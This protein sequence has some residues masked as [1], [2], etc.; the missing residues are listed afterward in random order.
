M[1]C[2]SKVL[3]MYSLMHW[4]STHLLNASRNLILD[5]QESERKKIHKGILISVSNKLDWDTAQ[6]RDKSWWEN[7]RSAFAI[8]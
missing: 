5:H 7:L 4:I 3:K 1:R 8:S 2:P 6:Q